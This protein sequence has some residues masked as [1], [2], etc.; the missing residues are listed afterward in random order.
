MLIPEAVHIWRDADGDYHLEWQTSHP[1]TKVTVAPVGSQPSEIF[2]DPNKV[3]AS[4]RVSGLARHK[5]HFFRLS[6]Q[7][8]NEVLATER[9]LGMQGTPNFRDFGGYS[10][11]EGRQV[12]WGY[13]FRSGQLSAL[14]PQ[15]LQ[16]LSSLQ[17]DLVCDFRREE[18]QRAEASR[19]PPTGAPR[20][21]S[22]PII[23]GSNS[24][25]FEEM[26]GRGTV[27]A[28]FKRQAMFDFMVEI[29]RDFAQGQQ[30]TYARM[31]AEILAQQEARF[32]V[33]CAAGKDRT[34]FAAALMLLAL[35]VPREVVLYDYLLT[36]RYYH[37]TEQ[38]ERLKVKY[39]MEGVDSASVLPMLEV[40]AD[41]L[42]RGLTEIERGHGSIE[43]YLDEALGVGPIELKALR[44]RYLV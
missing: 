1:D 7:Y 11:R 21:V 37:P 12:K 13:L 14:S 15:D 44:K 23:P 32:L 6:D 33:H 10:T 39:G 28:D 9:R 3:E 2:H 36:A 29:N 16:L 8:G 30:A 20:I 5:R 34:G 38:I 26:S 42:E 27:A 4:A 22:L 25:F 24:R 17:L 43:R 18:E 35:G 19:L 40:H 41:Y 31:F